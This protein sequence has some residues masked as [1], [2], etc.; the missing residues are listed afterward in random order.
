[1][2]DL[3]PP[4]RSCH[5]LV[6]GA[7]IAG[8]A[9]AWAL[10]RRPGIGPVVLLERDA[11]LSLTSDKSTECYRNWWQGPGDD[12]VRFANRSIDLLETLATTS[13]N[14]P[15]LD[16]RGYLYLSADPAMVGTLA[17]IASESEALGAGPF[18]QHDHEAAHYRPGCHH[19]FAD[20]PT[21]ADLLE[22]SALIRRHFPY[23]TSSACVALH[24]RRAGTLSAQQLGMLMLEQARAAGVALIR[25]ELAEVA[26]AAGAV[27]GV[28]IRQDDGVT[29]L[30]CEHLVNAA[31]PYFKAVG[32][33][34]GLTLP[35]VC[36]RHAKLTFADRDAVFPRSAPLSIWCDPTV[37]PWDE[38]ERTLLAESPETR[39]L[40]E[41]FPAGVHGR[42]IGMG[43]TAM[44]YWTYEGEVEE[45]R[46]PVRWDP[47]YPEILMRGMSVMVP[48]LAC[49]RQHIPAAY[50]D[51]G[52]YAKTPENRPLIGPTGVRGLHL[53]GAFSGFGIMTAMAGGDLLADHLSGAP[54]PSY[55]AALSLARY[56]D[57]GYRSSVQGAATSGQL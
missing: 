28:S 30:R 13:D 39:R 46:Y 44:L 35:V 14:A 24:V 48:G 18:R 23:A 26:V 50:V 54:L 3:A 6:C 49:Y 9:T 55:A 19:G 51:G 32:E 7:G 52:Y 15:R 31:G 47:H 36:E 25:G 57:A 21:G 43:D 2:S 33:M 10:S 53:M 37:L 27:H 17:D 5:V 8:I 12:M 29:T 38:E 45:P 40:T 41:P 1:M 16:R 34:A 42:P 56:E 11:P 20:Q 4:L 22:G